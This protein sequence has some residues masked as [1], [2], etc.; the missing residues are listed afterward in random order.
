[1]GSQRAKLTPQ[2]LQYDDFDDRAEARWLSYLMYF[3]RTNY[4]SDVI[5]TDRLGF[6][7]SHG[8]SE[9]ASAGG[10]MPKGPVRL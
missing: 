3:H 2:M 9:P 4:R 5:N 8:A 10:N 7:I 1:M 6:R